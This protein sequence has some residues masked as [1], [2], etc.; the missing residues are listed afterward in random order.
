M[1]V[2]SI[3]RYA[4]SRQPLSLDV[5]KSAAQFVDDLLNGSVDGLSSTDPSQLT[6]EKAADSIGHHYAFSDEELSAALVQSRSRLEE[7]LGM[8]LTDEQ[9][10]TLTGGKKKLSKGE[11]AGAIVGGVVGGAAVVGTTAGVT[12]YLAFALAAAFEIAAIK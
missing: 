4:C 9:L 10:E 1:V 5:M 6:W 12:V 11:K 7:Q 3:R 8:P 2:N